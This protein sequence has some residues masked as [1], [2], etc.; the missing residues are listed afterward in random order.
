ML[1]SMELQLGWT[2]EDW[3]YLGFKPKPPSGSSTTNERTIAKG[4]PGANGVSPQAANVASSTDGPKKASDQPGFLTYVGR[5][6]VKIFGLLMTGFAISL[7]AP[8]WFDMLNKVISI[9]SAGR[10]PAERPKSP[11]AKS[12]RVGEQEPR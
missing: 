12:K 5:W 7:G 6:I 4:A 11:E 3:A 10:S 8:F 2:R 9:R 1:D